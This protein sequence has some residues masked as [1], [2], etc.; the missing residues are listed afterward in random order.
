MPLE[1]LNSLDELKY[2]RPTAIQEASIPIIRDGKDVVGI[3][4]TVG[5]KP[6]YLSSNKRR[7]ALERRSHI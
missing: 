5:S 1:L 2:T 7:R 4:E 6:I 3:A